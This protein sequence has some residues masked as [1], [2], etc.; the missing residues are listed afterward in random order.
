[1]QCPNAKLVSADSL[2]LL[3]FKQGVHVLLFL[4][5][6]L[7]WLFCG[8]LTHHQFSGVKQMSDPGLFGICEYSLSTL[9]IPPKKKYICINTLSQ[10]VTRDSQNLL[11][12]QC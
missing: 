6:L 1:M 10:E 9:H 12:R 2:I 5:L 4:L 7:F 8:P 3:V 11:K